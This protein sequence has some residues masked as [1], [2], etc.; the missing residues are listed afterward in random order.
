MAAK[1]HEFEGSTPTNELVARV[2]ELGEALRAGAP[3]YLQPSAQGHLLETSADCLEVIEKS[4]N[5]EAEKLYGVEG[6]GPFD[7][8]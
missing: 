4:V 2:R 3:A 8:F 1:R 7:E 6:Q 5:W